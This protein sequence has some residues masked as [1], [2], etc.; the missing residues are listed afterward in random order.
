MVLKIC[1]PDREFFTEVEALRLFAG[2]G[3]VQLLEAD[4]EMGAMLL[5]RIEPGTSLVSLE[6]ELATEAAASV[7]RQLWQPV[8]VDHEFPTVADWAAEFAR[9]RASFAGGTG[10]MPTRLVEEAERLFDELGASTA[11]PVLLHGDLH[12]GNVLASRRERWLV[13]DPKG[14]IGEPAFE[15]AAL[16]HKP[17]NLLSVPQPGRILARRVDQLS[18]HLGFDQH[19]IRGWGSPRECWPPTGGWRTAAWS[20]SRR[21]TALNSWRGWSREA[22]YRP[23]RSCRNGT[24]ST[25]SAPGKGVNPNV[26]S[27]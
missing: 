6:D 19:R 16:L 13:I 21:F 22:G 24:C 7:M 2:H 17:E 12:H 15:T 1:V 11:P 14:V 9:L 23:G 3:A 10:P 26:I 5:E 27:A 8:P 25:V 18:E 4:L 20:G